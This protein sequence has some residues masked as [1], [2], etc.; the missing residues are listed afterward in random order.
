MS[1]RDV[2]FTQRDRVSVQVEVADTTGLI[3]AGR[4][5]DPY[6]PKDQ[7]WVL[8]R[9]RECQGFFWRELAREVG[10]A[11]AVIALWVGIAAVLIWLLP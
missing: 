6:Y 8:Q 2:T 11:A 10:C 7:R 5:I 4:K 9:C 3:L 1:V